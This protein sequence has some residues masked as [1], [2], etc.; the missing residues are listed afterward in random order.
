MMPVSDACTFT[1]NDTQH[2]EGQQMFCQ[3]IVHWR[4]LQKREKKKEKKNE[5][6]Y[7]GSHQIA[8]TAFGNYCLSE[9]ENLW[10]WLP[11]HK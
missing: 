9:T 1:E 3:Q 4:L 2:Q 7:A 10:P 5:Q 11:V 8:E 6:D